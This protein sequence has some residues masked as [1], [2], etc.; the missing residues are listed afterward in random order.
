[1]KSIDF[2][3]EEFRVQLKF[4]WKF[5]HSFVL[6]IIISFSHLFHP[7]LTFVTDQT[8]TSHGRGRRRI[9]DKS[10]VLLKGGNKETKYF[11]KFVGHHWLNVCF[12]F[13]SFGFHS[14][15]RNICNL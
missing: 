10:E 7:H 14:I 12:S 1:M 15:W 4:I 9:G 3:D 6:C 13:F 2:K 11:A 5:I 8:A